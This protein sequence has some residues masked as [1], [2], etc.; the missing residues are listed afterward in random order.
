MANKI[1]KVK[2]DARLI[3]NGIKLTYSLFRTVYE[4]YLTRPIKKG[5]KMGSLSG[6]GY[7]CPLKGPHE[8]HEKRETPL[9]ASLW[10]NTTNTAMLI[11]PPDA[12]TR[13]KGFDE[14]R[15]RL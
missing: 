4:A 13:Y 14:N 7:F 1:K 12:S 6:D 10:P 9:S 15:R 11:L 5:K 8:T 3:Y 2:G